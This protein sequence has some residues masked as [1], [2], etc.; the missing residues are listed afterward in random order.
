MSEELHRLNVQAAEEATAELLKCCASRAWAR[1]M[2][3]ER[4]FLDAAELFAAADRVWWSLDEQDW[5]E[6]FSGHPKIGGRKAATE[7]S[8]ESARW[9]EAEQKGTRE[10]APKTLDALADANRLYEEK[11]GF[12]Y[13]VC[14]TGKSAAEL[15]DILNTRLHNERDAELRIAAE[16]QRRITALRL[17]KLLNL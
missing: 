13:I 17:G 9:S 6:A 1:A 8:Q 5:L 7:V 16:E 14:A 12:I 3:N 2:T 11:F 4:P 10:A 15:L